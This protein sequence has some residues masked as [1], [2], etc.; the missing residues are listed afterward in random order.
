MNRNAVR[1]GRLGLMLGAALGAVAAMAPSAWAQDQAA[2]AI[3]QAARAASCRSERSRSSGASRSPSPPSTSRR[4]SRSSRSPSSGSRSS[5]GSKRPSART[6]SRVQAVMLT[7]GAAIVALACVL[8]S[9]RRLAWAVAPIG[10]EPRMLLEALEGEHAR[11]DAPLSGDRAGVRPAA[12]LGARAVRGVRRTRCAGARCAGQRAALRARGPPDALGEGPARVRQHRDER[13]PPL[14]LAGVGPWPGG[15]RRGGQRGREPCGA[16]V[17]ARR[18][19][20]RHRGDRL[21][22]RRSRAGRAGVRPAACRDR[23]AR[24]PSRA[25]AGAAVRDG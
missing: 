15:A 18:R 9:G 4:S 13:G 10:L 3:D 23:R 20:S 2:A 16:L 22:R 17:R 5:T 8:A 7:L 12:R 24:H 1:P 21:L 11:R 19:L 14:R 6:R 25:P